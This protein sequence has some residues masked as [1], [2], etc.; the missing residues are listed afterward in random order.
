MVCNYIS[1]INKKSKKRCLHCGSC[2]DNNNAPMTLIMTLSNNDK[3]LLFCLSV[4][5]TLR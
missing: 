5:Q 3:D 1:Y 2:R 4:S